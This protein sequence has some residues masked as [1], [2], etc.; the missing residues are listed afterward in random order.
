M[1]TLRIENRIRDYPAW[2]LAFDK[3]DALRRDKGV[4]SYRITRQADDPLHIFID[5]DFD[6]ATRAED[7]R[8][9]LTKIWRTPQALDH[10]VDH[11]EPVVLDVV[12][13]VSY[14]NDLLA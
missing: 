14:A 1:T 3:Y 4:R 2:K 12:N 6:T 13:E 9:A 5:L 8:A 7:F 11:A 10:L